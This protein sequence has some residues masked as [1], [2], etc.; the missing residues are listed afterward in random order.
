MLA[1]RLLTR[2]ADNTR[3]KDRQTGREA[4]RQAERNMVKHGLTKPH[5]ALWVGEAA[6]G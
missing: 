3:H 5:S 2:Q 1:E 4:D 6:D